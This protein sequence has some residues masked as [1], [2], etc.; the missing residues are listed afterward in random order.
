M[1]YSEVQQVFSDMNIWNKKVFGDRLNYN[2][3]TDS[4]R[5]LFSWRNWF[6]Q[7]YEGCYEFE[8]KSDIND[9]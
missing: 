6:A 3:K 9:W 1:L 4:D 2:I 5:N 7:F 8:K